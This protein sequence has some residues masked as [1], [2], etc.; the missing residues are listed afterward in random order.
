MFKVL[1][2]KNNEYSLREKWVTSVVTFFLFLLIGYLGIYYLEIF[3]TLGLVTYLGGILVSAVLGLI[4]FR[5]PKVI[6][7][8]VFALPLLLIGS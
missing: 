1:K 7:M 8:S 5:Y 6:H 3:Q 2:K 4:G